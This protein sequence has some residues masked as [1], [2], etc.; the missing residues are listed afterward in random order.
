MKME[1][2]LTH[3]LLHIFLLTLTLT[4][5]ITAAAATFNDTTPPQ[6]SCT[7]SIGECN[8]DLEILMESEISRRFLQQK[9]YISPGALKRDQPVCNNGA[10]GE[11]YSRGGGACV[12]EQSNPY[13]RGCSRYYQCRGDQ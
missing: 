3:F 4:P 2:N 10:P 7:G 13:H 11:P 1:T 5:P 9:R 6:P 12:P 8:Q